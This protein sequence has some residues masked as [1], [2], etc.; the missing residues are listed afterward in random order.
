VKQKNQPRELN[1][2]FFLTPLKKKVQGLNRRPRVRSDHAT[3]TLEQ[4]TAQ[5]HRETKTLNLL[6]PRRA[7]QNPPP[8]AAQTK[9]GESQ[10]KIPTS[11]TKTFPYSRAN[12]KLRKPN[13]QLQKQNKAKK[14]LT[15]RAQQNIFSVATA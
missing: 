10:T 11:P 7:R 9:N 6:M 1:K 13:K 2:A 8:P 14:K 4:K 3:P 12:Q 15:A 5:A